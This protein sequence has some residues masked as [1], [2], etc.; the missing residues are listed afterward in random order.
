V[1]SN[2]ATLTGATSLPSQSDIR[3]QSEGRALSSSPA[4]PLRR[5]ARC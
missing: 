1:C 3:R 5:A 2:S 4:S